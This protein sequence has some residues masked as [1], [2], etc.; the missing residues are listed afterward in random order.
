[1]KK[2]ELEAILGDAE[3]TPD[4]GPIED[5]LQAVATEQKLPAF[6]VGMCTLRIEEAAPTL[7][8][9]LLRAA[10]GEELSD[11]ESLLLF[12]GL[13]ILGGTRDR[14]A[15]QP[16]L[17]LLRRPFDEVNA[18]LGDIVIESLANIVTGVFD[19]DS[20]ALFALITDRSIDGLIREELFGA[21]TFLAWEGRI[22][23]DRY[24]GLLVRFHDERMA[25]DGDQAWAGWLQA[26][27]LLG[28]RDL[29]PLVD[30]A[31]R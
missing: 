21:T 2:Q 26:I 8:G 17:R 18:L 3:N 22:Q 16:L 13:H 9:V 24:R 12:R 20:D 29:V 25:E 6:A 15:C 7:R 4:V 11:D 23:R 27:A 30:N 14:E 10:E 19:D 31:F 1:M 28:L 5:Y